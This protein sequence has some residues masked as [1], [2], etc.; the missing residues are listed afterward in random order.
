MLAREYGFAGWKDL[1]EEV[2]QRLGGGLEWAATEARRIIHDNDLEA[3]RRLLSEHPALLSWT[4]E[5]DEGGLLGMAAGSY[6][7]SLDPVSEEHFT[8]LACAEVLL[9]AGA[10]V[11]PSVCDGLISSRAIRM[12]DLFQRRG[13]F[14][15]TLK[16]LAALGD[17]EVSAQLWS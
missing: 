15:R 8:R 7:D 16:F 3:L 4:T 14:P 12:I 17:V 5:E 10:V 6:G 1:L 11:A 2:N 13:L 9:D